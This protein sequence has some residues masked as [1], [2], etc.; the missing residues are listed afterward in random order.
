MK[1]IIKANALK[2]RSEETQSDIKKLEKSLDLL[3]S[4]RKK[5]E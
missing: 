3:E 2:R 4:K 1:L 5:L